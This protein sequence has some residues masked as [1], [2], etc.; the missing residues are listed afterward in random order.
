MPM[1]RNDASPD[2]FVALADPHRRQILAWLRHEPLS[3]GALVERLPLSQP[4]V[5][6]HLGVLER[7]GLIERQSR[8]RTRI[9]LL[10]PE[11]LRPLDAW[12]ADY[13][14]FWEDALDRIAAMAEEA[15]SDGHDTTD[16]DPTPE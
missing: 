11:G 1:D 5:T 15:P 4:G 10:T 2:L 7:A 16:P 8:G 6:K 9:C 12:L 14:G 3:V 13:R